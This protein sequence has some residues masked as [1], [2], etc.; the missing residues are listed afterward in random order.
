MRTL[1][2]VLALAIV[3]PVIS[4]AQM[5]WQEEISRDFVTIEGNKMVLRAFSLETIA[6]PGYEVNEFQVSYYM[7]A[8]VGGLISRDYFVAFSAVLS[9][10][11]LQTMMSEG[12]NVTAAEFLAAYDSET[13]LE[14]IGQPDLEINVY[15]TDRGYQLEIINTRT[16]EVTRM[17]E[18]WDSDK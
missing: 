5:T 17:T 1:T 15:M 7:D 10:M 12:Y 8:P 4:A 11:V 16:Q 14:P 6:V 3:S 9:T 18:I 2:V 13:L